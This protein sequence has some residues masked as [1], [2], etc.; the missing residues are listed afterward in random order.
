V[1]R[2]ANSATFLAPHAWVKHFLVVLK[3]VCP[4]RHK[5]DP[6][7]RPGQVKET[8]QKVNAAGGEEFRVCSDAHRYGVTV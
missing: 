2:V 4:S 8:S 5:K 3:D 1:G 7:L 6:A